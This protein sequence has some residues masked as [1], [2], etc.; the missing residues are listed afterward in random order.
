MSIVRLPDSNKPTPVISKKTAPKVPAPAP[1][2]EKA[3]LHLKKAKPV[4]QIKKQVEKTK[5]DSFRKT[6]E[7]LRHSVEK[8]DEK[9]KIELKNKKSGPTPLI[10]G[11][12]LNNDKQAALLDIYKAEVAYFINRNWAFSEQIAGNISAL[13]T[14]I[15]FS[16]MPDGQISNVFFTEKSGNQYFNDSVYKA[17]VKSSPVQPHPAGISSPYVQVGLR[18]TPQGIK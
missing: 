3:S 13:E 15:V 10:S 9:R 12:S 11:T 1:L 14:K 4:K 5:T 6:L 18:F 16:V 17:V 2:R 7:E 8:T